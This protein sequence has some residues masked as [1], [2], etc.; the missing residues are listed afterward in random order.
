MPRR[1]GSHAREVILTYVSR[2]IYRQRLTPV[3]VAAPYEQTR[4][5]CRL[6]VCR[7][8]WLAAGS[9]SRWRSDIPSTHDLN[10]LI[11][12]LPRQDAPSNMITARDDSQRQVA[13]HMAE[14]LERGRGAITMATRGVSSVLGHRILRCVQ[15]GA[16]SYTGTSLWKPNRIMPTTTFQLSLSW[17]HP[18]TALQSATQL[19]GVRTTPCF[20]CLPIQAMMQSVCWRPRHPTGAVVA[21]RLR[22]LTLLGTGRGKS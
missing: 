12:E 19:C 22:L 7:F 3:A 6:L 16:G 9:L 13:P 14:D 10:A 11:S 5:F 8:A 15:H 2:L 17:H 18:S 21:G 20:N 4:N 1:R